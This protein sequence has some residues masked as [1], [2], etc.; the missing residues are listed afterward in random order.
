MRNA[1]S[2]FY[3][4]GLLLAGLLVLFFMSDPYP[5]PGLA[6][7]SGVVGFAFLGG[8]G[9][10][11]KAPVPRIAHS[12]LLMLGLALSVLGLLAA[13]SP[14]LFGWDGP[15]LSETAETL[16]LV[17]AA[18]LVFNAVLLVIASGVFGSGD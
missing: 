2:I 18:A 12:I 5:S 14:L 8:W 3:S 6:A 17:G 7:F 10:S 4:D 1:Q 13:L 15:P 9:A 11:R 16:H